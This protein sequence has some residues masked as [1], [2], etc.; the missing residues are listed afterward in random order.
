MRLPGL[1][2]CTLGRARGPPLGAPTRPL[3]SRRA[4]EGAR[5]LERKSSYIVAKRTN[6]AV[7]KKKGTKKGCPKG[8]S[9]LDAWIGGGRLGLKQSTLPALNR[10]KL[11]YTH[12]LII[13]FAPVR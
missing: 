3:V 10:R 1:P 5:R 12:N 7:G 13:Q 9:R 4:Y 8:G 11:E 6:P 2:D